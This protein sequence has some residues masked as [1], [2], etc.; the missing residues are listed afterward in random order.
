MTRNAPP[1]DA[2]LVMAYGSPQRPE[3]VEPYYTHIR[4]GRA[5]SPE[6][7][8]DLQARY[9]ALLAEEIQHPGEGRKQVMPGVRVRRT[10][11]HA[12]HH[13]VVFVESEG[14]T[15]VFTADMVP[16]TRSAAGARKLQASDLGI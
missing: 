9:Y 12:M 5:P 10:G 15:A 11:G 8:A 1:M 2:I 3:D 7:L 13:E 16:T 14:R 4:R 6:Q